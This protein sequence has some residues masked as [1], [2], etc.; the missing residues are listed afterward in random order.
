MA[1]IKSPTS[2]I[3]VPAAANAAPTA[4]P[5]FPVKGAEALPTSAAVETAASIDSTTCA[6]NPVE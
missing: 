1:A 6:S 2:P 5:I 3:S 4:A